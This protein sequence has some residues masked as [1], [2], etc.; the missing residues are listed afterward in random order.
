MI[1]TIYNIFGILYVTTTEENIMGTKFDVSPQVCK[2]C[3]EHWTYDHVCGNKKESPGRK[4]QLE[5]I[6]PI[7][8][9][10][11]YDHLP[12]ELQAISMTICQAAHELNDKLPDSYEKLA[13]LRRLLEAKDCFVRAAYLKDQN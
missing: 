3:G 11:E 13:G 5:E 1:L 10:F 2:Q 6:N 8:K 12:K 4:Y 9:F 7:M